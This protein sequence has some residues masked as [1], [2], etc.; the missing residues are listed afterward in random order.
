MQLADRISAPKGLQYHPDPLPKGAR[1]I[2]LETWSGLVG[3][4]REGLWSK[5]ASLFEQV[6]AV[7]T[8][9]VLR[10]APEAPDEIHNEAVTRFGGYI[11]WS[12][13]GG[14]SEERLPS[15]AKEPVPAC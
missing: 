13:Y 1:E 9:R 10:Y 8:A 14:V 3:T 6:L 2:G 11:L 12:D 7:A 5:R 4:E 15:T